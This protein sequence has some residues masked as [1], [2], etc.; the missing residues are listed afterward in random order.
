LMGSVTLNSGPCILDDITITSQEEIDNF[1]DDHP[2]CVEVNGVMTIGPGFLTTSNAIS[3]LAGL[4][5]LLSIEHLV[6]VGNED[7]TDLQGLHNLTQIGILEFH[8]NASLNDLTAL[9]NISQLQGLNVNNNAALQNL[10]GLN[11][12]TVIQQGLIISDNQALTS[13]SALSSVSSIPGFITITNNDALT[14]LNGLQNVDPGAIT[15][16]SITNND[17]LSICAISSICD[18][19]DAGGTATVTGNAVCCQSVSE[20]QAACDDGLTDNTFTATPQGA[21]TE[22]TPNATK[23]ITFTFDEGCS[24]SCDGN[25]FFTAT[26]TGSDP[27]FT[28]ETFTATLNTATTGSASIELTF[29]TPETG[30]LD[31][32]AGIYQDVCEPPFGA[33]I[34]YDLSLSFDSECGDLTFTILP[35]APTDSYPTNDEKTFTFTISNACGQCQGAWA[36]S[37]TSSGNNASFS[38]ETMQGNLTVDASGTGSINFT[39]A[40][41]P[42]GNLTID[43]TAVNVSCPGSPFGVASSLGASVSLNPQACGTFFSEDFGSVPSG[44]GHDGPNPP[45]S[46]PVGQGTA[47]FQDAVM[48]NGYFKIGASIGGVQ[49]VDDQRLEAR[50]VDG[51]VSWVSD[52]IMIAS[53]CTNRPLTMNVYGSGVG[54]LKVYYQLPATGPGPKGTGPLI[55][56]GDFSGNFTAS[57]SALVNTCGSVFSEDTPIKIVV[58]ITQPDGDIFNSNIHGFDNVQLGE[59]LL[60][61]GPDPET[62][63]VICE[64]DEV[65]TDITLSA[66]TDF[67]GPEFSLDGNPIPNN[68]ITVPSNNTYSFTVNDESFS[69]CGSGIINI[70]VNDQGE[71]TFDGAS[72]ALPVELIDLTAE[73]VAKGGK[74]TWLTASE[75]NNKQ[76]V[77]ERAT[78]ASGFHPIGTIPGKGNT[79]KEQSYEFID[80]YLSAGTNYYRL[81]Q[82]DFDGE[83]SYSK[84]VSLS[85]NPPKTS[86]ISISPNPALNRLRLTNK[87]DGTL[88]IKIYDMTGKWINDV[89]LNESTSSDI[90]ISTW[91]SGIYLLKVTGGTT[92]EVVRIV[93]Q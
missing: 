5:Q 61:E 87:W 50:N 35:E 36:I 46:V 11:N 68:P 22:Y 75:T 89:Q 44:T 77:V 55:Q 56:V 43:A 62:F 86:L 4:A 53:C 15:D 93:K 81:K 71:C 26:S 23:T 64:G 45:E 14:S 3:S 82:E 85:F 24:F 91:N 80:E 84:I 83:Y 73:L 65:S 90:N 76:F 78:D 17:Q 2:G 52:E 69:T 66:Q 25:W 57:V 18:Y 16:L 70:Y 10:A 39:F 28:G 38:G 51:E 8:N 54:T 74:L 47:L 12:V 37:A 21:A 32:A 79:Q 63:N 9:M 31:I 49:G 92:V 60:A 42:S 34:N 1:D 6:I 59:G 67:C 72:A 30:S 40:T 58:V 13:L 29:T 41:P 27:D 7:L 88:Y 48:A 33:S 19:L 20:I